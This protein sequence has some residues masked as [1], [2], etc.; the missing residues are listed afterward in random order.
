MKRPLLWGIITLGLSISLAYY[1]ISIGIIL[2]FAGLLAAMPLLVKNI[3]KSQMLFIMGIFFAG[4]VLG[5]N[6]FPLTAPLSLWDDQEVQ[7]TGMVTDYPLTEPN[8]VVL[9]LKISALTVERGKNQPLAGEPGLQVTLYRN[10]ST[11]TTGEMMTVVPG[12]VLTLTGKLSEPTGKR[13]PGGFDYR[14]YLNSQ[15]IEGL[16]TVEP[17]QINR[18]GHEQSL[19]FSILGIKRQLEN[20]CDSYFSGAVADLLKGV[21]FGEKDIDKSLTES[22]QNAGVT[23]VLSVSGLH[24]GY[25]FLA[26]SMILRA[27]KIDRRIWSLF[28]LPALLFYVALTGFVAPV[29][30]AAIMIFCLTLGQGLHREQDALNQLCLAGL[31]IL[32]L[33]PCQLFQPGFQLSMGAMLGIILFYK[34]VLFLYEK[35]W[36][37]S[38]TL[39]RRKKP[40]PIMEGLVLTLSA[41]IGTLPMLLYHFK[42]FTFLSFL[43]NL[44]VV[45]LIGVFLL[46]GMVFLLLATIFPFAGHLL[47]MPIAFLGQ[48]ILVMLAGINDLGNS[49]GFLKLNRGGLTIIEIALFV[50]LSFL[51]SGY[52]FM[53]SRQ[54]RNTVIAATSLLVLLLILTPLCPRD[55]VVTVL[56]VGQGDSILIETPEG[57]NYLIDG[58]GYLF[59]RSSPISENVLYP[60][61]YSK[62]IEKLDGVF[63]THNH[64]DHVQGIEELVSDEFPID[65][66][67]MSIQTNSETLLTQSTVPVTL[68][69]KG[70]LIQEKDGVEIEVFSPA[71]EINPKPD[72]EQNNASLVMGLSYKAT[73]IMLCGD[74]E[75]ETE[76]LLLEDMKAAA[77]EKDYQIIKIAHH[78]G[79]NSSTSAFLE[80][81]DPEMA[82]ISVGEHNSFGHPSDEV[83][84]RLNQQDIKIVRTDKNGA[85]EI[86][87]N[88]A[89]IHCKTYAD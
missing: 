66:L 42:S 19:Y 40:G 15:S 57:Q 13:N 43:S 10:D 69:K 48:S 73:N 29:V 64:V 41:T 75:K 52:F 84:N 71:G 26:L 25:V 30:R 63:L 44:L 8:R 32:L 45:P 31:I 28:L 9:K 5:D 87:S 47:A 34:P 72:D 80:A 21:I 46:A 89:S 17:E 56:D 77:K 1:R 55:L 23:H 65:N 7:V 85:V 70:S 6:A 88:G 49:L 38:K 14:L 3:R 68:L 53:K 79:K 12:D 18:V 74:I 4:I 62:N 67:F 58:G 50:I 60:V 35:K 61:L 11:E 81:V 24:V 51:I 27:L 39:Q 20:R 83:L 33:W 16:M 36:N 37:R 54:V 82:I 78:G 22:F 86:T 76:T 59:A 2:V